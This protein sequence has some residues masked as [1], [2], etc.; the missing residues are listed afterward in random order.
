MKINSDRPLE[1]PLVV[2]PACKG[3]LR[4]EF[5]IPI[6]RII[7]YI[8]IIIAHQYQLGTHAEHPLVTLL[9]V[10]NWI[11]VISFSIYTLYM[12]K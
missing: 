1:C 11:N 10:Y 5:Q 4:R 9:T 3:Y 6:I 8:A 2:K 12:T 7:I